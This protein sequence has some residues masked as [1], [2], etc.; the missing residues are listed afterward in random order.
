M[1]TSRIVQD[2]VACFLVLE[3]PMFPSSLSATRQRNHST[4]QVP[5]VLWPSLIVVAM[6]ADSTKW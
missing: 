2:K 6:S 3:P 5:G 4:K 1:S